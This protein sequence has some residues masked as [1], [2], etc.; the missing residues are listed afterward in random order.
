MPPDERVHHAEDEEPGRAIPMEFAV[1]GDE[2]DPGEIGQHLGEDA[3]ERNRGDDGP[4]DEA[5]QD[6]ASERWAIRAVRRPS[7]R[8]SRR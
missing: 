5:S 6:S 8:R 4:D 2:V 1:V 7:W 3:G